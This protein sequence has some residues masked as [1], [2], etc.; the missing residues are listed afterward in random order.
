MMDLEPAVTEA[1]KRYH[2]LENIILRN[3]INVGDSLSYAVVR[4][5]I[6]KNLNPQNY[7]ILINMINEISKEYKFKKVEEIK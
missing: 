6:E 1:M 4:I 2:K 3:H 7:D 5:A